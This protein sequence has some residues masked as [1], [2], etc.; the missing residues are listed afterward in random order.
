MKF[1]GINGN[2]ISIT[3]INPDRQDDGKTKY[4]VRIYKRTAKRT[5]KILLTDYQTFMKKY[6]AEKEAAN[7]ITGMCIDYLNGNKKHKDIY[8]YL[9]TVLAKQEIED[10][11]NITIV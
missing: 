4:D 2:Y 3:L 8:E 10:I 1:T 5:K 6:A 7:M 11:H 9:K